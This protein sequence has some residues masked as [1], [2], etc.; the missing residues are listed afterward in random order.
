MKKEAW[1]KKLAGHR[2][3]LRERFLEY[4]LSSFTDDEIL[5]LLLSLG[6]P[7]QDCKER[8][9]AARK[10]FG[11]LAAVL[12]APDRELLKIRGIGPNNIFA[13]KFIHEVARKFL[14]CRLEGKNYIKAASDMAEYLWHSLS[15]KDKEVFVVAFLD[16]AHGIIKIEELFKGTLT[17]SVVY[18]REVI[19]KAL[20]YQAAALIFAHNHPSGSIEPSRADHAVTKR[21]FLGARLLDIQVLDHIIIG[22]PGS[23]LSF[24]EEGWIEEMGRE[25][26]SMLR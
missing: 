10:H 11:S 19:K 20:D 23:Y 2:Q 26:A 21:L 1:Q 5:E 4:G 17:A 3:R 9:R 12:E 16:A 24:A 15:F 13:L 7:R 14:R 18:P 25:V 8:A 6:T 22:G